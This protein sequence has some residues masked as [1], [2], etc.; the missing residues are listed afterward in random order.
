MP[1]VPEKCPECIA[2]GEAEPGDVIARGLC[3]KHYQ[4]VRHGYGGP[5]KKR[6]DAGAKKSE[7]MTL[8]CANPACHKRFERRGSEV[9]G[10]AYC[11]ADCYQEFPVPGPGRPSSI[12]VGARKINKHGYVEVYVGIEEA[13]RLGSKR[14]GYVFE[15]RLVM[16]NHL[17]RP[18]VPH[19]EV[20]H[21]KGGFE[22]RSNNAL[23][24]LELWT[25]KHPKGHRVEDVMEYAREMLALYGTEEERAAYAA[26]STRR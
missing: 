11:S 23:S 14:R 18:L 3:S 19:E 15:H 17:G 20:H 8:V 9:R 21:L 10:V 26:L 12:P 2:E 13:K 6:S 5:R 25:V 24:N 1:K 22:G 16:G 7:W 4:R